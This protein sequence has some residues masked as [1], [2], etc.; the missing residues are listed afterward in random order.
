M[1]KRPKASYFFVVA[2]VLSNCSPVGQN[3]VSPSDLKEYL[4]VQ[5]QPEEIAEAGI[6]QI[7]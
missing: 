6:E 4:S 2:L 1:Y 3:D 5:T 7:L